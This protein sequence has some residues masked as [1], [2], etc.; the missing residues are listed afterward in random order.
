M[1]SP[2]HLK[3][4]GY[5]QHLHRPLHHTSPPEQQLMHHYAPQPECMS[6]APALPLAPHP[7]TSATAHAQHTPRKTYVA[8][9]CIISCTPLHYLSNRSCNT[10]LVQHACYQ[11]LHHLLHPSAPSQQQLMQHAPRAA[12]MLLALASSHTALD[13]VLPGVKLCGR[14]E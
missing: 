6:P 7:T 13:A 3:Q 10:H 5:R 4:H 11:R 1:G 14:C 9:T 12:C 8:S 2:T